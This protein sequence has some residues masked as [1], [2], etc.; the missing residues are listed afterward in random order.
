LRRVPEDQA[1]RFYKGIDEPIGESAVSLAD[2]FCKIAEVDLQSISFHQFRGHFERW[3]QEVLG[4]EE[5]SLKISRI[6]RRIC[7]A[8]RTEILRDIKSRMYNFRKT[9]P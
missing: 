9:T 4:D 6:S 7:K 1:F 2:L 8:L 3:I 5:L